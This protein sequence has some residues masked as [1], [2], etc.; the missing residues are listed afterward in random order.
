MMNLQECY[1]QSGKKIFLLE[2]VLTPI[3]FSLIK[4]NFFYKPVDMMNF[5]KYFFKRAR[6]L[7]IRKRSETYNIQFDKRI[8]F[9]NN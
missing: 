9:K 1:F 4:E 2:N 5:P 8:F 6:V 3:I 7:F